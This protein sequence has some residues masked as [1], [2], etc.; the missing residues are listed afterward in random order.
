MNPVMEGIFHDEENGDLPG[1]G[2][3]IGEWHVNFE[4]EEVHDGMED[5]DLGEF[6]GEV[7]KKDVFSTCPLICW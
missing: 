3:P 2:P 1:H 5:I 6:D 7:L 4:T